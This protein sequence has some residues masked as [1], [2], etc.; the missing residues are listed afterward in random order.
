MTILSK[1]VFVVAAPSQNRPGYQRAVERCLPVLAAREINCLKDTDRHIELWN[2]VGSKID[3]S[4][5]DHHVNGESRAEYSARLLRERY[6]FMRLYNLFDDI[7]TDVLTDDS[8]SFTEWTKGMISEYANSGKIYEDDEVMS[9]CDS[10]GISE[11]V[12]TGMQ[13]KLTCPVCKTTNNHQEKRTGWFMDIDKTPPSILLPRK[14]AHLASHAANISDRVW[15]E[16]YRMYG[17]RLDVIG[18]DYRLDPKLGI[19]LMPRYV[20]DRYSVDRFAFIQG[21]DTLYNTAPYIQTLSPELHVSYIL[22]SNIPRGIDQDWIVN[23]GAGFIRRYL[24]LFTIDRATDVSLQQIIDLKREY[25]NALAYIDKMRSNDH[26]T[27]LG[28]EKVNKLREDLK[29]V[30]DLMSDCWVRNSII[31]FRKTVIKTMGEEGL[32]NNSTADNPT[33]HSARERVFQI[34]G[35]TDV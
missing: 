10:C 11:S 4:Y 20:S 14:S 17:T 33:V 9:V 34:Y 19:S 27:V 31:K 16:R 7:P 30:M 32:F 24:P 13:T 6:D 12:Y 2:N 22:T 5:E 26:S 3:D 18:S 25:D 15:I 29:Q 1:D 21:K 28:D 35:S 23:Y 8:E